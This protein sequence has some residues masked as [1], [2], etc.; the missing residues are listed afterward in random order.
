MTRPATAGEAA[1]TVWRV[2]TWPPWSELPPHLHA[3]WE[4]AA[5]A[6]LSFVAAPAPLASM[7]VPQEIVEPLPDGLRVT[8]ETW[9]R[10]GRPL[11][12]GP[13]G[14]LWRDAL[15]VEQARPIVVIEPPPMETAS[16]A[17]QREAL[18]RVPQADVD[19]VSKR[20]GLLPEDA[21]TSA[22]DPIAKRISSSIPIRAD[23]ARRLE[24]AGWL[25]RD[26]E[27]RPAS[28]VVPP[29]PSTDDED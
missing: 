11:P 28:V 25:V 16:H 14:E 5:A 2:D 19:A 10:D 12:K 27:V 13:D 4:K 20:L 26:G 23:L 7:E 6:V 15:P 17:M 22:Y 18:R 1:Y 24:D 9:T 29:L 8:E 21:P 3:R